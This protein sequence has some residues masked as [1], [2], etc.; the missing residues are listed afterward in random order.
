[1]ADDF[2]QSSAPHFR[3]TDT[4]LWTEAHRISALCMLLILPLIHYGGRVI[5]M[6]LFGVLSAVGA[7]A[8]WNYIAKRPQTV[9]DLTSVEIGLTCALLMPACAHYQLAI[10]T[11]AVAVT[12]GKMP[13]GG[14]YR[15]PF[16]PAAV[17]YCMAAVC[18]PDETFTYSRL[19]ENV[20]DK[21]AAFASNESLSAAY[22]QLALLRQGRD[23]FT[24]INEYLLGEVAG[25]LGTT[26]IVLLAIAAVWLLVGGGLA[27]QCLV[28]FS[29]AGAVVSFGLPYQT[30]G[31]LVY[32][33]YDLLGGSTFFC[34]VFM[35][36]CPYYCPKLATAR[37]LWGT[38]CGT[39]A[40]LIQHF[41]SVEAGG[42][43]AVLLLCPLSG[44]FDRMV[45]Y[46]RSRNI[47]Y[48]TVKAALG[49][50]LQYRMKTQ[51]ERELDE[52]KEKQ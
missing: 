25:P 12:V 11:A 19:N 26:S 7:E 14:T 35:A 51:Q 32:I 39:L 52:F 34:C 18:F 23:P 33:F 37:Y 49:K 16:V 42:A 10:F 3:Q 21:L 5:L 36:C 22:S 29:L 20:T 46:F 4:Q 9:S 30:A 31:S 47:S 38:A 15:T 40:V 6:V 27:W 2:M 41:G 50:R 24:H 1:M 28:S 48:R 45:W 17:G 8:L 43:F 44:A 13:F